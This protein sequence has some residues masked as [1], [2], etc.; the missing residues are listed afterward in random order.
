MA[1][2]YTGGFNL[3]ANQVLAMLMKKCVSTYRSWI[4]LV[5]QIAMPTLFLIIAFVVHRSHKYTGNLPAMP[6]TLRKFE[7]PVTLMEKTDSDYASYYNKVLKDYGY[8]VTTVDN[9]T[10]T[11]LDVVRQLYYIN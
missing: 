2:T 8:S 9:M 6:L 3:F 7:N 11:M 5:I 10:Q 4:L 1:P